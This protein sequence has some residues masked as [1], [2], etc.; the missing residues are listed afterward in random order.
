MLI[1]WHGDL[2]FKELVGDH[3]REQFQ[4]FDFALIAGL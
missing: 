4:R 1:A 3:P 2:D